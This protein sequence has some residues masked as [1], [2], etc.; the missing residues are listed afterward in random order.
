[1]LKWL[2]SLWGSDSSTPDTPATETKPGLNASDIGFAVGVGGRTIADAAQLQ[3]VLSC[4]VPPGEEPT[5]DQ[6]ARA[7]GMLGGNVSEAAVLG[8]LKKRE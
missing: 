5:P 2:R 7:V 1:M 3:Y 4:V 8:A 6:I